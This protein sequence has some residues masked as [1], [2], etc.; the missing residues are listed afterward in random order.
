LTPFWYH[1]VEHWGK[2]ARRSTPF[3]EEEKQQRRRKAA[4][5][6]KVMSRNLFIDS[7]DIARKNI[8]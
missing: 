3:N 1:Q 8:G 5:N 2:T 4:T 6:K 7:R